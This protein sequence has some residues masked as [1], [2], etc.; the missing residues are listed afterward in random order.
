MFV[1][2]ARDAVA[3]A[4]VASVGGEEEFGREAS[5]QKE[6]LPLPPFVNKRDH[7]I[8]GMQAEIACELSDHAPRFELVLNTTLSVATRFE[9]YLSQ[10][11]L[12]D[13]DVQDVEIQIA[14]VEHSADKAWCNG[15]TCVASVRNL[16]GVDLNSEC[17]GLRVGHHVKVACLSAAPVLDSIGTI[18]S[19]ISAD[20]ATNTCER[21]NVTFNLE[22]KR[23]STQQELGES[24]TTHTYLVSDLYK[25]SVSTESASKAGD[26]LGF[27][28]SRPW[29]GTNMAVS[30]LINGAVVE[31]LLY[32]PRAMSDAEPYS[33]AKNKFHRSLHDMTK[34]KRATLTCKECASYAHIWHYLTVGNCRI[35]RLSMLLTRIWRRPPGCLEMFRQPFY[36]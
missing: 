18:V 17:L 7:I 6:E 8:I 21:A 24:G 13:E 28:V 14:I 10:T 9:R 31:T 32:V 29:D 12:D 30:I 27:A 5:L 34:T 3:L 4:S 23:P 36:T 2:H 33:S 11:N 22:T 25:V 1:E 35:P 26:K 16:G 15:G 20:C 19:L